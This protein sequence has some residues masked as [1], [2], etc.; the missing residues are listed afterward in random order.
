MLA[1]TLILCLRDLNAAE[2]GEDETAVIYIDLFLVS[3]T[4]TR[5]K[6]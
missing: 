6:K 1:D 2:V 4:N 5:F 3:D